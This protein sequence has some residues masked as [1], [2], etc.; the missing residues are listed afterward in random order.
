[1]PTGHRHDDGMTGGWTPAA[2]QKGEHDMKYIDHVRQ[3]APVAI[4]T[5][6]AA[7]FLLSS[8]AA[9]AASEDW[10]SWADPLVAWEDGARQA[11]A[12][13]TAY[14]KDGYM[15]NHTYYKDPRPGGSDVYTQTDYDS[16]WPGGQG[17]KYIWQGRY[18][19]DQSAR[20]DSGMW[21]NQYDHDF[22][23]DVDGI[24]K[25]RVY[26]KVCEDQPHSPDPCSVNPFITFTL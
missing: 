3:I 11:L 14:T 4:A 23:A 2:H 1:M 13:G 18:G 8:P 10:N 24:E 16:Y 12:Y 21:V 6:G 25:G 20:D 22:Y 9:T 26:Y 17:G 15:K 5:A 19:K 7:L